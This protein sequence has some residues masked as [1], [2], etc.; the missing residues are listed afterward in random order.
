M[1]MTSYNH[2]TKEQRDLIQ[3]MLDKNFS[4]SQIGNAIGKDRTTISKEIRRNR[5]L[6]SFTHTEAFDTRII[7][8][9]MNSCSA[10]L[11]PPYV[12]N[13]CKSRGGCR[14]NKLYYN[15]NIAHKNYENIK[16]GSREGIDINQ[17]TIDE[18]EHAIIPLIKNKNQSV[19]QIYSNHSDI[20]YFSKVT[21]YKYVHEGVLSITDL[22]LPKKVKYKERKKKEKY[23]QNKRNL[24]LLINRTYEDFIKFIIKHPNMNIVEM[25]TV[26]GTQDSSKV[27]LTLIIRK[28]NFMLIRLMDKKDVKSVNYQY[29]LLKEKLGSKLFFKIFR[30][31]LTDNGSEFFDPKHIEYDYKT[32]IKKGNVFYCE[33]YSSWQKGTIEKNHQYIRKVF[34]K[35]TSFDN[36]SS[37]TIKRLEDNINNV[38]R[39]ILSNKTPYEL[40]KE[41]YPEFIESLNCFYIEPDEVTLSQKEIL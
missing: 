5:Y 37:E 20:L 11:K 22:D 14:K 36:F 1:K 27:L 17:S 21:F 6:K 19:N 28:T 41:L 13:N 35:G 25:D 32:K 23:N 31:V 40:T 30:I 3:Y 10:L 16:K 4:F 29:D 39:D 2:L 7:N 26:E 34:P 18:I 12:C 8:S 15:S 38:P 24:A 9:T 33:P